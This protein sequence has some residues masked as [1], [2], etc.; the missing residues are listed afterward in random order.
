MALRLNVHMN[1]FI[2]PF[3]L[4]VLLINSCAKSTD[5]LIEVYSNDFEDKNLSNI[6]NGTI[7]SFNGSQVLGNYNNGE[8]SLLI[9]DLPAHDI[10]EVS[11]DLYIH[12]S[13]E[14][15]QLGNGPDIWQMLVDN[16]TFINTT[17]ANFDCISGNFCP[18]QSYPQNYPSQSN[19]PKS[20]AS[21]TDLPGFC[22]ETGKAD[23]TTLYKIHK[24]ISHT[25]SSI[26]L[27]CLDRL[28]QANVNDPRCD[29][30]WSVD[31]ITIKAIRR[32]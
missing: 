18:P 31:N 20:G 3:L 23:G 29:E 16:N 11:F 27:R 8:F 1:K 22:A 19:N 17:F 21:R 25:K 15:V 9:D 13:W 14:G 10:I 6:T 28:K 32:N 7:S 26:T 4:C 2:L 30:S 24:S 5:S 12:D